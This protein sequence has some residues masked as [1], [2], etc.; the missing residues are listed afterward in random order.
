MVN[1]HFYLHRWLLLELK[2]EFPYTEMLNLMEVMWSS[3]PPR[4]P[5][6]ELKLY[7]IKFPTPEI[8]QSLRENTAPGD[9]LQLD[10]DHF[11]GAS[12][13]DEALPRPIVA[14]K[15]AR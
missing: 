15:I 11:G 7:K 13:E 1:I 3:L 5:D 8:C 12:E 4:P 2:R 6:P 14:A 9:R 10:E